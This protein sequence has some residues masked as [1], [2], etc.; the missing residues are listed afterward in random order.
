MIGSAALVAAL[1]VLLAWPTVSPAEIYRWTDER[2]V[3]HYAE[4]FAS[5]PEQYRARAVP[6]GLHNAQPV[7]PPPV[8][9][10]P[11]A[12]GRVVATGGT[13]IKFTPGR[14]ILVDARLNGGTPVTLLL[15]TGAQR[16]VINPRALVAAGVALQTGQAVQM[17]GATGTASVNTVQVDSV[18]VGEARVATLVVISHDI[19]HDGVDGL[20][21]RDFL[22][23]FKV[24]IDN[25]EGLVTLNPR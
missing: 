9:D 7:S 18:E 5:V 20:L 6:T 13:E 22:D 19:D 21:G 10:R 1:L 25:R 15:D 12:P 23:Q 4:G 24:S 2:G 3:T 14:E 17:K 8:G 11:V 16:T